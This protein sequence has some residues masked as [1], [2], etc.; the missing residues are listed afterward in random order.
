MTRIVIVLLI[1]AVLGAC[2]K[3]R[4]KKK[5]ADTAPSDPWSIYD[6]GYYDYG[7]DDP[8]YD[9]PATDDGAGDGGSDVSEEKASRGLANIA[10]TLT[11]EAVNYDAVPYVLYLAV[12]DPSGAWRH[13]YLPPLPAAP[14][15]GSSWTRQPFHWEEGYI[16]SLVLEAPG[17]DRLDVRAI[18]P[19]GGAGR[20]SFSVVGATLLSSGS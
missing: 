7:Y 6:P 8:G 5:C 15:G 20:S 13:L 11:I 14:A 17:G 10:P 16:Y 12:A 3:S 2:G 1:L 19:T 9:D 18:D 4:H